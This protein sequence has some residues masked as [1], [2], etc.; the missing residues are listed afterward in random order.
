MGVTET[1]AT[2]WCAGGAGNGRVVKRSGDT[3]CGR[4]GNAGRPSDISDL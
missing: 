2:G 3:W 4:G 1:A